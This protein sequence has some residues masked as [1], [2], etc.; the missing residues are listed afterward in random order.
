MANLKSSDI[1]IEA[2]CKAYGETPV[3]QSLSMQIAAGEHIALVGRSGSGKSTLLN[4]IG[5]LDRPDSG[6]IYLGDSCIS[7]LP[8]NQLALI[9]RKK[10]GFVFQSFNLI[11]TLTVA[12]NIL[13]PLQLNNVAGDQH[14]AVQNMLGDLDLQGLSSRFPE[15]LSG[16]QQ[17]RVAIARALI[18]QPLVLLADEPTGNLDEDTAHQVIQLLAES[19]AQR[20]VSLVMATHSS[21]IMG[22]ANKV[23]RIH[24]GHLEMAE[25]P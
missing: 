24:E 17:Q 21:E 6:K 22:L 25:L 9:R 12:E 3:L 23:Y 19:C 10:I 2:V 1:R 8:E 7:D 14:Q 18:H 4:L 13:L 16:G 11:P 15:E 5:G 20:G